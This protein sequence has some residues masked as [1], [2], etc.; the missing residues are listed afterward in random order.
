MDHNP[1]ENENNL[2]DIILEE[3][4]EYDPPEQG[5]SLLFR[6]LTFPLKKSSDMLFISALS[7]L[8]MKTFYISPK[9]V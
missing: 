9:K 2:S 6:F 4:E 8:K 3:G 1:T 7:F 5:K